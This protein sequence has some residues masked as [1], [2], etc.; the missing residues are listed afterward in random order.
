MGIKGAAFSI[1]VGNLAY[2]LLHLCIRHMLITEENVGCVC[3]CVH[4]FYRFQI[5]GISITFSQIE[6]F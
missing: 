5:I 3:V 1:V 6:K 2:S 4:P